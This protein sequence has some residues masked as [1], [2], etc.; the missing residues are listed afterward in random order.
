MT[1]EGVGGLQMNLP[2]NLSLPTLYEIREP[3][4]T[5]AILAEALFYFYP[6]KVEDDITTWGPM[7]LD[8]LAI[9]ECQK[10]GYDLA[11]SVDNNAPHGINTE[12]EML[13]NA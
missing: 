4:R 3:D 2:T 10:Y 7:D 5:T 9:L 8:L 1:D 6:V 11:F 12:Q 13:D